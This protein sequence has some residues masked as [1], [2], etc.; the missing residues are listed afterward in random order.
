MLLSIQWKDDGSCNERS[1]LLSIQWTDDV[2][3]REEGA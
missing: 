3:K 2:V 1:M